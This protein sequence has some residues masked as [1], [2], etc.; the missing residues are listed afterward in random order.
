MNKTFI[1]VIGYFSKTNLLQAALKDKRR[2]KMMPLRVSPESSSLQTE[3]I[4]GQILFTYSNTNS[5]HDVLHTNL[6]FTVYDKSPREIS[7]MRATEWRLV[8]EQLSV[9]S[10]LSNQSR[11]RL[12][13]TPT[14]GLCQNSKRKTAKRKRNLWQCIQNPRFA[15]TNLWK[16]LTK[17]EACLKSWLHLCDWVHFFHFHCVFLLL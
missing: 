17:N 5:K 3:T 7:N 13:P 16:T 15:K 6:S 12:S 4:E 8:R 11:S 10:S 2:R 9:K 14:R 1:D